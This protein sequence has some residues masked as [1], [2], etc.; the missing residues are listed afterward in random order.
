MIFEHI[1]LKIFIFH[2][3]D[4]LKFGWCLG[5][6]KNKLIILLLKYITYLFVLLYFK[7]KISLF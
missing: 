3:I 5:M 2:F 1:M 4:I 6:I 7:L